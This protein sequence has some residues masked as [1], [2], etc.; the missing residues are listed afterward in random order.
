MDTILAESERVAILKFLNLYLR[1]GIAICDGLP[2]D[3]GYILKVF[4]ALTPS[5]HCLGR[6]IEGLG[7][8]CR[9][10]SFCSFWLHNFERWVSTALDWFS[11]DGHEKS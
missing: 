9:Q 4:H 10:Q 8:G 3:G 5:I 1:L 2:R 7:M 6:Y 11:T